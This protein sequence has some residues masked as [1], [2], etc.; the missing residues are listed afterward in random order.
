MLM[1]DIAAANLREKM[2]P[3]PFQRGTLFNPF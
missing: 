3:K 2:T 1:E